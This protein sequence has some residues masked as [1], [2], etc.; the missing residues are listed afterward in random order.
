MNSTEFKIVKKEIG[1]LE[2]NFEELKQTLDYELARFENFEVGTDRIQEAKTTRA[3]LNKIAKI[4]DDRRK[5]LKDEFMQPYL[6]VEEQSKILIGMINKVNSGIDAKI[7][8]IEE[9]EKE[10]KKQEIIAI[11]E[12]KEYNKVSLEQVFNDKWLNKTVSLAK[13]EE[14][15]EAIIKEVENN[16]NTIKTLAQE[17]NKVV[18]LQAKYLVSLDLQATLNAYEL[19]KQAK[20]KLVKHTN[21]IPMVD[22]VEPQNEELYELSFQVI[23]TE[24][25][26]NDLAKYLNDNKI[27]F[28]QL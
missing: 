17:P 7:K 6:V 14:E 24:K 25:Q 18:D 2:I 12:S 4:I 10:A 3:N 23:A 22:N 8:E 5:Q 1:T 27:E 13:A 15:M 20:E 11:W 26:I 16:L 19:E 21:D 9:T 28:K